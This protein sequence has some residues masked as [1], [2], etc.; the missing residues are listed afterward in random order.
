MR[1]DSAEIKK[2]IIYK[3][4]V[5]CDL[6]SDLV[7]QSGKKYAAPKPSRAFRFSPNMV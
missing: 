2:K 6:C 7:K 1:P 5:L 3:L 4:C